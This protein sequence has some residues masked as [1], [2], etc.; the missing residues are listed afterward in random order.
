MS[1]QTP[2]AYA[3]EFGA[4][5]HRARRVPEKAE[6][7]I[8]A[9]RAQ[10]IAPYI[11]ASDRVLE[12]GVGFGWNLAA[13]NCGQKIGFDLT[14]GLKGFVEAKGIRF[15]SNE[16][17]LDSAGYDTVLAHHVLEHVSQPLDCLMRLA[18][19]LKR[20]GQLLIF[21]PFERERKYRS[22]R[23]NDRAH[24]LFSWTPQS[25]RNLTQSSGL[26]IRELRV[27][28]FRFDRVA[29]LAACKLKGGFILYR[30]IRS[31]GLCVAPEY[32]IALVATK[33]PH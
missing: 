27:R 15:E 23:A 19:L 12:Y 29:A 2:F 22:F 9:V 21:V 14:P 18:R 28:K 6:R 24:H 26:V 7:W 13:L 1:S 30:W 4:E 32:E 5:Y 10:K 8:A 3:Q 16:A 17:A 20:A 11:R 31:F 33:E 25:L